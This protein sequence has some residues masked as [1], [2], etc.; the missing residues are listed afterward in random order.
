M[1]LVEHFQG[2]HNM[3]FHVWRVYR[4]SKIVVYQNTSS[5]WGICCE[6]Y[7]TMQPWVSAVFPGVP[8]W[9]QSYV[10]HPDKFSTPISLQTLT[11]TNRSRPCCGRTRSRGSTTSPVDQCETSS[12]KVWTTLTNKTSSVFSYRSNLIMW[13]YQ[14]Y[15]RNQGFKV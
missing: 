15:K 7:L 11:P 14:S 5:Y 12:Q 10:E 9:C 1:L 8:N 3:S 4:T 13:R 6:P 2:T